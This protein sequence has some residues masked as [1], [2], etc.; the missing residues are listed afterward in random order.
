[1]AESTGGVLVVGEVGGEGLRPI[2]FEVVAA[3]RRWPTGSVAR[4][5]PS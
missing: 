2:S 3:G 4:S 5:W 1:M